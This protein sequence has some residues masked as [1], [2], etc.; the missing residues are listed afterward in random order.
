[1]SGLFSLL[2][3]F[4]R[5]VTRTPYVV[6]G[7][8]LFVLKYAV[9]AA[10]TYG[11]TGQLWN[12]LNYLAPLYSIR[13]A[14]LDFHLVAGPATIGYFLMAL[15]MLP[16]L[17]IGVSMSVRRAANAGLPSTVGLLFMLPMVNFLIILLLSV[18][19]EK[20]RDSV[21]TPSGRMSSVPP[22]KVSGTVVAALLGMVT[23]MGVA[24]VMTGVSTL[25]LGSYGAG[26]FVA[27]PFVIGFFAAWF[28]NRGRS[29][30]L[31]ASIGVMTLSMLMSGAIIM[32][33]ALEGLLCLAMAFP[34]A[35]VIGLLGAVVGHFVALQG[36]QASWQLVSL[37]FVLPALVAA[38]RFN[39]VPPERAATTVIEIDAPPEDVWPNV[40]GFSELPEDNVP[41]Y[42]AMGIA[43]PQRA[44]IH[45]RGVGAV[46]HCEFSTGPFV[47][48]ITVWDEP[49]RL[50]F[51]VESQPP[52]MHEWS[53][54]EEVNAPHVEGYIVSHRGEFRLIPLDG[55]TRTRLEGTTWYHLDMFPQPY[56]TLFSD[57]M[58][59]S[60]HRRV[61]GH[62]ATLSEAGER[63]VEP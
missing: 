14:G 56:W 31:S 61:L 50:A 55:G 5:T 12:P 6:A 27:T 36:N 57:A 49:Y 1:M 53:P 62:I 7:L 38:E 13:N 58:L 18:L 41:W 29:M 52:S 11:M 19:P 46:R 35:W 60:I 45:G 59:H 39:Q 2:F 9:D 25:L 28:L 34:I 54:W 21:P 44:V 8:L 37:V 43:Y 10:I 48:P 3:G 23:G 17:W 33:F 15:W 30:P 4:S 22:E 20:K 26:L 63:S 51:D 47:E 24:A 40:I 16:F 32:L 42:F